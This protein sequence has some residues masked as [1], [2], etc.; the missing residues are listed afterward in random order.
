MQILLEVFL[1]EKCYKFN[2]C[3]FFIDYQQLKAN[4][5]NHNL[6]SPERKIHSDEL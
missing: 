6:I 5:R 1:K 4:I 2:I 3:L